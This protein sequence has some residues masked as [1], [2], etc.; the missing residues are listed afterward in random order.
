VGAR[1]AARGGLTPV[2][3]RGQAARARR[4]VAG[5]REG[6]TCHGTPE[7]LREQAEALRG[8]AGRRSPKPQRRS[9]RGPR[10][11]LGNALLLRRRAGRGGG[12]RHRLER[13]PARASGV[14]RAAESLL[15]PR[16]AG[17][18]LSEDRGGGVRERGPRLHRRL[19]EGRRLCTRHTL[20]GRRQRPEHEHTAG[21]SEFGGWGG[22][23]P[24]FLDSPVF[25]TSSFK[26]W[27]TPSP[28]RLASLQHT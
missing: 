11:R 2:P 23:T 4:L 16:A 5:G 27:R 14:A 13:R 8:F 20:P 18:G 9:C 28:G 7:Q 1:G 6:R 15:P 12:P 17:I 21:N 24:A 19:D 3:V 10:D 22:F 25:D 26:P